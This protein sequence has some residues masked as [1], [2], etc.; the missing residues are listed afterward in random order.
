M[1][2]TNQL[3]F[4]VCFLVVFVGIMIYSYTKDRKMHDTFYKGRIWIL[5]AFLA[6][7]GVLFIIK[8]YLM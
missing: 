3:I 1:F 2:S 5:L 4:A 7:I 6:F 8:K